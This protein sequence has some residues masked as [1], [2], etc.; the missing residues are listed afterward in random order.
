MNWLL[1]PLQYDFIV[2]ALLAAVILGVVC[3]LPGAYLVLRALALLVVPLSP[4][5]LPARAASSFLA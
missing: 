4:P 1:A 3:S 5:I 2:R